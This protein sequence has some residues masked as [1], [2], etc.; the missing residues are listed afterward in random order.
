MKNNK[1]SKKKLPQDNSI[2]FGSIACA[3]LVLGVLIYNICLT[4]VNF[5]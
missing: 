4:Y 5:Q 1:Q 2:K 3:I